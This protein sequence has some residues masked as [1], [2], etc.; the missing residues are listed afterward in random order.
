MD[1]ADMYLNRNYERFGNTYYGAELRGN[2]GT[3]E[4][5][6]FYYKA[7]EPLGVLPTATRE[8]YVLRGWY[9]ASSGG[10]AFTVDTVAPSG[11]K[12]WYA[13]WDKAEPVKPTEPT[14]TEP[15]PTEPAP[16]EPAPT[17]PTTPEP[18][19]VSGFVDVTPADWFYT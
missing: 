16:T 19:P 5:K 17:E 15:A 11:T 3:P 1:E 12:S 4:R 14:P 9:S 13:I 6:S 10:T 2:G 18:D 8:G 7:G